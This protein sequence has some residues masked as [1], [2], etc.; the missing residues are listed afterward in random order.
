MSSVPHH[1]LM[2]VAWTLRGLRKVL[3]QQITSVSND[4]WWATVADGDADTLARLSAVAAAHPRVAVFLGPWLLFSEPEVLAQAMERADHD[5]DARAA[6]WFWRALGHSPYSGV[7][8]YAIQAFLELEAWPPQFWRTVAAAPSWPIT[9]WL[10]LERIAAYLRTVV[11][12]AAAGQSRVHWGSA[13][14]DCRPLL[15]GSDRSVQ[16]GG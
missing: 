10:R 4:R 11:D 8:T 13:W 3:G 7:T 16:P 15:T 14:I 5:E 2:P 9:D 6:A 12:A 1:R